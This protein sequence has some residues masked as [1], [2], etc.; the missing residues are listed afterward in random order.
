MPEKDS[1][2]RLA[3]AKKEHG[4]VSRAIERWG[5]AGLIDEET[6]GRL[7]NSIAVRSFDWQRTARYAFLVSIICLVIAV[8]ALVADEALRKL[9]ARIFNAPP[10]I[11]SAFSPWDLRSCFATALACASGVHSNTTETKPCFSSAYSCWQPP[12]SFSVWPL[13][14]VLVITRYS[15]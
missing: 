6:A 3:L 8:G 1:G 2:S 7:R 13:I 4:M 5:G 10:V 12:C 11:K 15:S 9:L 14:P